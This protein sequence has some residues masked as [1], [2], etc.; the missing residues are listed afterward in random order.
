MTPR[1]AKAPAATE[2]STSAGAAIPA[3]RRPEVKDA[4]ELYAEIYA[5]RLEDRD[6]S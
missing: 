2:S 6:P 4:F 1:D 3:Q 5:L